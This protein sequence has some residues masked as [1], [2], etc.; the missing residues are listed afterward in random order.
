MDIPVLWQTW[1]QACEILQNATDET[2]RRMPEH[3]HTQKG[4]NALPQHFF[5]KLKSSFHKLC[6]ALTS[7]HGFRD[8]DM[9]DSYDILYIFLYFPCVCERVCVCACVCV[10]WA[11]QLLIQLNVWSE[12][13]SLQ[14]QSLMRL[15]HTHRQTWC[16]SRVES[17]AKLHPVSPPVNQTPETVTPSFIAQSDEELSCP[18]VCLHTHHTT[19][20]HTSA[21]VSLHS[22]ESLLQY[23]IKGQGYQ[24]STDSPLVSNRT[25]LAS[26][27]LTHLTASASLW[28]VRCRSLPTTKSAGYKTAEK[29]CSGK[30]ESALT[31]SKV[32]YVNPPL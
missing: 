8:Q 16:T 9:E 1:L 14:T 24:S 2:R 21:H 7:H 29:V 25:L 20:A 10:W 26:C 28:A 3:T 22:H 17:D 12:E 13:L 32:S 4:P 11:Q 19:S 6:L 23:K 18:Y 5:Q 15:T 31:E 30:L 27:H